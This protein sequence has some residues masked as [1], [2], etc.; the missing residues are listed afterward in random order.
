MFQPWE[1]IKAFVS[2]FFVMLGIP[3]ESYEHVLGATQVS[4]DSEKRIFSVF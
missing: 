1:V 2:V 4:F 3:I